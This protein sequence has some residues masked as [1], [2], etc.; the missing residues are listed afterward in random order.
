MKETSPQETFTGE[1]LR[2]FLKSEVDSQIRSAWGTGEKD[3]LLMDQG[4]LTIATNIPKDR[5]TKGNI[6]E[7]E[8]VFKRYHDDL[9]VALNLAINT[10]KGCLAYNQ[11]KENEAKLESTCNV[12]LP[13]KLQRMIH[14]HSMF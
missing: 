7:I 9:F 12:Y 8:D 5:I 14:K 4:K 11:K 6:T 2:L 10:V 3:C 1:L 13:Y